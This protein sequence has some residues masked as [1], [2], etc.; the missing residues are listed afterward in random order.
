MNLLREGLFQRLPTIDTE[1]LTL[2]R[3]TM[4]DADDVF[5][6]SSDPEVSRHVLWDAH[7]SI[8]DSRAYLR[9]I[10]RQYRVNGP[11]SWGIEHSGAGRMIGT[12]GFMWWNREYRS[13]E[14]GYSLAREYWNQGL[15]TEALRAVIRFGFD[16]MQL[17]RIEAQHETLN[18]ASG[19]VMEKAGMRKEGVLRGRL[20]N[21][22]RHV[23]VALYAILRGDPRVEWA[24]S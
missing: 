23:D 5:A 7:R 6:Y 17:Y 14:V 18:P 22:G 13:A 4:A 24:G 20:C 16:E 8:Q 10:L 21:K 2:R 3:M 15:M 9:Y 12:I 19:R 11:S 1:R